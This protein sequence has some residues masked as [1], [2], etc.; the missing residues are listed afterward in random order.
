MYLTFD[1]TV[2][3]DMAV[4]P[5]PIVAGAYV[6]EGSPDC[7]TCPP[8]QF[9]AQNCTHNTDR[10]CAA[11]TR[12]G[13]GT[14]TRQTCSTYFDA[15]CQACSVCPMGAYS[16]TVCGAN[17]NA[18]G[19]STQDTACSPCG[20]CDYLHYEA[21]H[22]NRTTNVICNSCMAC[23]FNDEAIRSFCQVRPCDASRARL[24]HNYLGSVF[25][26]L[27][28]SLPHPSPPGPLPPPPLSPW[29]IF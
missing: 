15:T 28:L 10:V 6:K 5:N 22:C 26:P 19:V 7:S 20:T 21:F 8:N 13:T 18:N 2:F 12:C 4:A 17:A 25:L 9:V 11:C 1:G 23:R 3:T 29:A 24:D 27:S 14:F 16:S